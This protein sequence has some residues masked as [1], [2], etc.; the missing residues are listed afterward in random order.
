M[1]I[2]VPGYVNEDVELVLEGAALPGIVVESALSGFNDRI[3]R[4]L[5]T[6]PLPLRQQNDVLLHWCTRRVTKTFN[7]ITEHCNNNV[8]MQHVQQCSDGE[9][10]NQE[11][12]SQYQYYYHKHIGVRYMLL[13]WN[14]QKW[15]RLFS[16]SHRSVTWACQ[17]VCVRV[18][19]GWCMSA[20]ACVFFPK[21]HDSAKLC[22]HAC[23]CALTLSYYLQER[24]IWQ[25]RLHIN[26]LLQAHSIRSIQYRG[27]VM[28]SKSN[29]SYSD[30]TICFH[31]SAVIAQNGRWT[32]Y[33]LSHRMKTETEKTV[34]KFAF[35]KF[36]RRVTVDVTGGLE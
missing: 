15:C 20:C 11:H 7:C 6:L 24:T 29:V 25:H 4:Y 5:K 28:I 26:V 17:C 27:A 35:A 13:F 21:S 31:H 18:C 22:V 36:I 32:F 2:R 9:D 33:L 19:S 16:K 23:M 8:L 3:L 10:A 1:C 14:T 12:Q 30:E 34:S